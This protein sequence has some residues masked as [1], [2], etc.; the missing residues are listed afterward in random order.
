MTFNISSET[1]QTRSRLDALIAFSFGSDIPWGKW[2]FD[3]IIALTAIA[4]LWP[5]MLTTALLIKLVAPGPV[6]FAHERIGKGGQRFK[7]YKFRTMYMDNDEMLARHL[8]ENPEAAQEWAAT[9]KLTHD[10]RVHFVG[11]F[12]RKASLDEL[13]QFFNVLAGDMSIV[14]PRPIVTDEIERYNR[15]FAAYCAVRPGITGAWQVGGRN[16]TGY[17]ERVALDVDYVMNATLRDDVR[18]VWKTVG[19][20]LS[21]RGAS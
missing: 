16:D 7:C 20:V 2:A 11:R 5:I 3:K 6:L 10:P 13:P 14:G 17:K 9:Q 8:A 19:V 15:D 1:G 12:L 18:I 21:T 4:L